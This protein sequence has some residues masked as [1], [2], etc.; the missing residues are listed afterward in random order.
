[1]AVDVAEVKKRLFALLNDTNLVNEYIRQYGPK[2]D[3]KHIKKIKAQKENLAMIGEQGEGKDPI[4]ELTLTCPVC[5]QE[6]IT[7]YELRA[8]TQQI[9]YSK[10]LVPVHTG[11][12]GYRSVDY[13]M[14]SVTICPR[15]LM[16]SSDKKDFIRKSASGPGTIK[17]QLPNMIIMTLQ[18]KIGERRAFLKSV[19][20]YE[21]FFRRP[22]GVDAAIASYR[23]AMLRTSVERLYEQPYSYYKTGAYALRIAQISKNAGI[24]NSQSL[25]EAL[26]YFEEAFRNSNCPAEDIEMQVIYTIAA[27]HLKLGNLKKANS[28]IGVF[29]NLRNTRAAEMKENP[30]L[31]TATIDKWHEKAKTLWE[32]REMEDLFTYE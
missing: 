31:T 21:G 25:Q 19:T 27:L 3:I 4:Y 9:T 23:L 30:R 10:F 32:D 16:A 18:E 1:M 13:N 15:C 2:M 14:L 17:S 7:C 20:D 11:A 12:L 22:R 5:N 6:N 26:K 29:Q 28:Y 8:K 24:D